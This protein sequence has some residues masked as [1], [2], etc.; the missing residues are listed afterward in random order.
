[1]QW[2]SLESGLPQLADSRLYQ[3]NLGLS[4]ISSLLSSEF[5]L[6]WGYIQ[7][8]ALTRF[9]QESANIFHFTP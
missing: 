9:P 6:I 4:P 2:R 5:S 1:M 8:L 3:A 7:V